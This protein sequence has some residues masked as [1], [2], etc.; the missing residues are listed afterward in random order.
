MRVA[1]ISRHGARAEGLW[2]A[3][4]PEVGVRPWADLHEVDLEVLAPV[5]RALGPGGTIMVGYRA[6]ETERALRRRVPPAATPLGLALLRAGCRWLKDWYFAEGGREGH[7]KLQGEL[8][9]DDRHRQRAERALTLELDAFLA[10]AGGT[11]PDRGRAREAL[12]LL[13]RGVRPG[14][15]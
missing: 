12:A 1:L 9:L 11:P 14:A 10:G 2:C 7:T 3:G 15:A 5:A 8:P 6:D 4:R 13:A